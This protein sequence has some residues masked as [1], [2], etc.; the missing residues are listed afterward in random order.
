MVAV[1]AALGGVVAA[2]LGSEVAFILNG[3][4]FALSA[5]LIT[6]VKRSFQ[7]RSAPGAV[8]EGH[9]S[10]AGEPGPPVPTGLAGVRIHRRD[11]QAGARLPH[12]RG[13][14]VDEDLVRGRH[15][16]R[17]LLAVFGR[18]V[19]GGGDVGIDVMYAARGLGALRTVLAARRWA[20]DD[21][22]IIR[23]IS[24][25]VL[26]F[27]GSYAALLPFAP[28]LAVAATFVF[29][30]HLGGGIEWMLSSCMP[31]SG[32]CP[33]RCADGCSRSTSRS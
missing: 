33:M 7:Q 27:I 16:R 11:A 5:L 32:G 19:F 18:D 24:V 8:A 10:A 15:E 29:C 2:T 9:G 1:G 14:P 6:G 26:L 28:G 31:S 30:A 17:V 4:S 3:V 23:A 13:L 12:G 20:G 22:A 21:R 25:A